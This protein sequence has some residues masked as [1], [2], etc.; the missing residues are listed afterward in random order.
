MI[1]FSFLLANSFQGVAEGSNNNLYILEI[2]EYLIRT[3]SGVG[4]S[5]G[6]FLTLEFLMSVSKNSSQLERHAIRSMLICNH[7]SFVFNDDE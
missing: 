3:E 2:I 4:A 6:P 7:Y 1:H 5:F